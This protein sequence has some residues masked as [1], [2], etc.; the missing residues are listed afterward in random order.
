MNATTLTSKKTDCRRL[1]AN[2]LKTAF[3]K[4]E[5]HAFV[6]KFFKPFEMH[7]SN[8]AASAWYLSWLQACRSCI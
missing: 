5:T 7:E 1:N 6:V 8:M 2:S 4:T 3:L